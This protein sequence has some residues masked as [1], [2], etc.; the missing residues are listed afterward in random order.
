V[1]NTALGR[2]VANPAAAASTLLATTS[3]WTETMLVEEAD[4]ESSETDDSSVEIRRSSVFPRGVVAGEMAGETAGETPGEASEEETCCGPA[5][6]L[7]SSPAAAAWL[8]KND[9]SAK[10]MKSEK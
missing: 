4:T 7:Q 8:P 6:K 2:R 9:F 1:R 10:A 5:D 3:E